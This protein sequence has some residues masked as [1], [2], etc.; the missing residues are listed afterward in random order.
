MCEEGVRLSFP[1]TCPA[2]PM[3]FVDETPLS[4]LNCLG[5]FVGNQWAPVC[6]CGACPV[7]SSASVPSLLPQALPS[8]LPGHLA[9]DGCVGPTSLDFSKM[10]FPFPHPLRTQV[11]ST[12]DL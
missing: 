12:I 3:P 10:A 7:P 1:N 8:V 5:A 4:L 6:G 2:V 9:S 11:N